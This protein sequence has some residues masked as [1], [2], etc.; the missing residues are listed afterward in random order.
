MR[1]FPESHGTSLQP[2]RR[3]MVWQLVTAMTVVI[4]DPDGTV[5]PC[6]E[7]GQASPRAAR[8]CEA[9]ARQTHLADHRERSISG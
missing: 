4:I 9:Q 6:L 7:S 1:S 5:E 2:V 8:V 3:C